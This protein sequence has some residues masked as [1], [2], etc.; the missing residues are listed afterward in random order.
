MEELP[1]QNMPVQRLK[2]A[3]LPLDV[4]PFSVIVTHSGEI[5]TTGKLHKERPDGLF[6]V[7]F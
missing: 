1:F 6:P 2:V 7:L 4:L 5:P 3:V